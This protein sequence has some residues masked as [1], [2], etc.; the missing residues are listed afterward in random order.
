M[1]KSEGDEWDAAHVL[2]TMSSNQV[3]QGAI[4]DANELR[5][6]TDPASGCFAVKDFSLSGVSARYKD[7]LC[8]LASV[9]TAL[10]PH[11][12]CM[13]EQPKLFPDL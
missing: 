9:H 8:V 10:L 5:V 6:V 3:T 4:I 13:C 2:L 7:H 1:I 11:S 12:Y